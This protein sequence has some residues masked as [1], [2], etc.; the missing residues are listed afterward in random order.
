MAE[1][2]ELAQ[3]WE[4][5]GLEPELAMEVARQLTDAGRP[6]GPRPR[7]AGAHART[8]PRARCRRPRTSAVA[9]TLGALVPLVAFL[10]RRPTTVA[11]RG[12]HRGRR[13]RWPAS[14]GLGAAL[15]GASRAAG[16]WRGSA[17]GGAAAMG[18]TL[19]IG[20]LTGAALG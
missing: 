8:R 1:L 3:I 7:R 14:A 5:R 10:A 20:E 16:P 12:G 18:I 6:G 17:V 15:G 9:F 4:A 19:L 11:S 13:W 2:R